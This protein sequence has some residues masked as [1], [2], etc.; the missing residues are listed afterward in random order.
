M[1][2]NGIRRTT[3]GLAALLALA[4]PAWAEEP[5]P[6]AEEIM[7]HY[8][9]VTGGKAAYDKIDNRISK[10]K[11]EFVGQ[12]I[13][14]DV[15]AYA[16]KPDLNYTEAR[17]EALGTIESGSN[18]EVAWE[19]SVMTGPRYMEGAEKDDRLRAAIFD[20]TA[21]WRK[22]YE[23]VEIVGEE[24]VDERVC[25]KIVGKPADGA[26]QTL[27]YD[28]ESGLLAKVESTLH[29]SMGDIPISAQLSDYREVDGVR[30]P[31]ST[32]ATVMGQDRV[33]TV[34]SVEH[35]V[36]MPA[37]RFAVPEEIQELLAIPEADKA[38]G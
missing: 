11:L 5:L 15:T 27:Y 22:V 3:I 10:A 8:V 13:S 37:E 14:L 24:S 29:S 25:Y 33:F 2:R 35:N 6:A 9:E 18:G 1:D 19:M 28:K 16:A 36:E 4:F 17:S 34:E 30:L 23:S 12:G 20:W 32:R 21:Y 26:P 7:D 38:D 31:F